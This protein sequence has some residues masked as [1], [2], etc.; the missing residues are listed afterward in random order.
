MKKFLSSLWR[1]S[2]LPRPTC[3]SSRSILLVTMP[4]GVWSAAGWLVV[5][6]HAEGWN[7]ILNHEFICQQYFK[8]TAIWWLSAVLFWDDHMWV[9]KVKKVSWFSHQEW[10][11]LWKQNNP[12]HEHELQIKQDLST[13]LRS[14][15]HWEVSTAPLRLPQWFVSCPSLHPHPCGFCSPGR[16]PGKCAGLGWRRVRSSKKGV[17]YQLSKKRNYCP[18]D[19]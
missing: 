9:S 12:D 10:S 4:W 14:P 1:I 17:V 13:N 15:G 2:W 16:A 6:P 8:G 19:S 5:E 7:N 11:P 18:L 3:R